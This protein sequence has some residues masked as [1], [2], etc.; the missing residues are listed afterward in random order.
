M[1]TVTTTTPATSVNE[2][3]ATCSGDVAAAGCQ[4]ITGRGICY[5][6]SYDPTIAGDHSTE[7]GSTGSFSSIITGLIPYTTYHFRAYATST[8]GTSYGAD[9][10]FVTL[11]LSAPVAIAATNLSPTGFT[12]NWGAVTGAT[13]YYLDVYTSSAGTFAT[14]LFI[15]EYVEGSSYNKYIEIF[16]GTV[17]SKNLADYK[18]QLFTNG[19]PTVS[20]DVVLS[21]TLQS[22]Q[23]IV[24]ENSL[25]TI[26]LGPAYFNSAVNF[27][28]NDAVAIYKISTASYTD[29]FGTIG[30]DPGAL[31]WV[32]GSYS[33]VDKTLVRKATVTGGVTTNPP[34]GFPHCQ[35]NGICTISMIGPILA[36]IPSQE[37]PIPI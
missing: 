4:P 18:L 7:T 22:G 12:A 29:I 28:G 2:F 20:T 25:A 26:Y 9:Q 13:G 15:S 35:L 21:G 11:N 30:Q 27:N 8:A 1:P 19:S 3:G 24:Y 37:Q 16:N 34:P 6:I 32:N 14:D 10:T 23:T 31:G 33:T 17:S 36:R 5:G